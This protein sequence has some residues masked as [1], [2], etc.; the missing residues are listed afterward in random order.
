MKS[1]PLENE[2]YVEAKRS[3]GKSGEMFLIRF[4]ELH[5]MQMPTQANQTHTLEMYRETWKIFDK[6]RTSKLC[7]WN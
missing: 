6:K 7:R 1:L 2:R 5:V 3:D 4:Y